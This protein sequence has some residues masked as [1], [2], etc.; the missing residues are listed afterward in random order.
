MIDRLTVSPFATHIR[1]HARVDALQ[2]DATF[3][4]RAVVVRP[5][6][7]LTFVILADL[8]SRTVHVDDALHVLAADS[9]IAGVLAWTGAEGLMVD[10]I[11]DGTIAAGSWTR[12]NVH[13]LPVD[14]CVRGGTLGVRATS[15]HALTA[16]ADGPT[17]ADII[18]GADGA[19]Q[20][21]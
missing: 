4:I 5:T 1:E 13:A 18:V 16:F 20:A 14:A 9:R 7:C 2:T 19:A 3:A 15:A 8:S 17:W 11:A 10:S 21:V 6:A 12:A